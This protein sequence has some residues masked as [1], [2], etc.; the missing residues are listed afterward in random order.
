[1]PGLIAAG[2]RWSIGSD[3]LVIPGA[4]LFFVH[5]TWTAGMAAV[6]SISKEN[7]IGCSPNL[8][9]YILGYIVI[10]CTCLV[11]EGWT[12]YLSLKGTIFY[13]RPRKQIAYLL[14]ARAGILVLEIIWTGLGIFWLSKWY[15]ECPGWLI[16][17]SVLG[18]VI[19]NLLL[20]CIIIVRAWCAY[21]S[22]GRTF[23]MAKQAERQLAMRRSASR[24]ERKTTLETK[25]RI[26]YEEKWDRRF[27]KYCCC[28]GVREREESA[29]TEVAG[30]FSEFFRDLD[31]VS[32]DIYAGLMLLREEQKQRRRAIEYNPANDT[33]KFLSGVPITPDTRFID[34]SNPE[35]ERDFVDLMHYF[36]YAAA[37][38]GWPVYAMLHPTTACCK[39]TS[40]CRCCCSRPKDSFTA[41]DDNCCNCNLA[42]L[43]KISGLPNADFVYATFHSAMEF[44]SKEF[45]LDMEGTHLLGNVSADAN[46]G[47]QFNNSAKVANESGIFLGSSLS[48]QEEMDNRCLHQDGGSTS[49]RDGEVERTTSTTTTCMPCMK[50]SRMRANRGRHLNNNTPPRRFSAQRSRTSSKVNSDQS[51]DRKLKRV[52]ET[53]FFIAL[54]HDRQQVVVAVRGT[55]SMQDWLTDLNA[56]TQNISGGGDGSH[57]YGHKGIV[58]AAHYIK[59]KLLDERLL[60]R[61]FSH[62]V[63][64]GTHQYGLILVGHSLGAGTVAILGMLLRPEFPQ[65][66]CYAYSP[67]GG[68]LSWSAAHYTKEF[69]TSLVIGK[70]LVIR[71]GLSQMETFRAD[72][73]NCMKTCHDAKWEIICGGLLCCCK[74]SQK[75]ITAHDGQLS[76]KPTR[77]NAHYHPTNMECLLTS[78]NPLYP[79][80]RIVH[81][82]RNNPKREGMDKKDCGYYAVWAETESFDEV[83][84]SPVMIGDHLPPNVIRALRKM[85]KKDCGYYAVWAETESFDE[86]LVSPVMIGDHLPPNVIRALRKCLEFGKEH[87]LSKLYPPSSKDRLSRDSSLDRSSSSHSYSSTP[88]HVMHPVSAPDVHQTMSDKNL[89][90]VQVRSPNL[91]D[92]Y[93]YLPRSR[94]MET[95]PPSNTQERHKLTSMSHD[96]MMIAPSPLSCSLSHVSSCSE[97]SEHCSQGSGESEKAAPLARFDTMSELQSGSSHSTVASSSDIDSRPPYPPVDGYC[98]YTD[99]ELA[100]P[101]SQMGPH[102]NRYTPSASPSPS[103]SPS[104]TSANQITTTAEIEPNIA[105]MEGSTQFLL[106]NS[107]W[108]AATRGGVASAIQRFENMRTRA[109]TQDRYT[110]TYDAESIDSS[111]TLEGLPIRPSDLPSDLQ[112]VPADDCTTA[113]SSSNSSPITT[114]TG[115]AFLVNIAGM[116]DYST[117]SSSSGASQ[118]MVDDADDVTPT[119]SV[120]TSPIKPNHPSLPATTTVD[121]E[122]SVRSDFTTPSTPETMLGFAYTR[123]HPLT[124]TEGSETSEIDNEDGATPT[125]TPSFSPIPY[126]PQ[127]YAQ[128]DFES[129]S[130]D[131]RVADANAVFEQIQKLVPESGA[132]RLSESVKNSPKRRVLRSSTPRNSPKRRSRESKEPR[133]PRKQTADIKNKF[134]R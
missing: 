66:H 47:G 68:L 70:D 18:I 119:P 134:I 60:A 129:D 84:V 78:H 109:S 74:I 77:I 30:L 131:E 21:D 17:N 67:P 53:P 126:L 106:P 52:W 56:D 1:M 101:K 82:L 81:I 11:L 124:S 87:G 34:F 22:A 118:R 55:L 64:R 107:P 29:F 104:E 111:T 23:V 57:W 20:V 32:S 54:D 91:R 86:V 50:C 105:S 130:D 38:Y 45:G 113:S 92:P 85:D 69:V 51:L 3:D 83:L 93:Q 61:A 116:H 49:E 120:T 122:R 114:P 65:L 121:D 117:T 133:E 128:R 15:I 72:L 40:R 48:F 96:Q 46:G 13:V 132:L 95:A 71:M 94:S 108:P 25:T 98:Y 90:I 35:E 14:Y 10:L 110:L 100:S 80:G 2:R 89:N 24:V 5:L 112:F 127:S 37:A 42:A 33:I 88:V 28:A 8:Y 58:Q 125:P 4:I 62:D 59:K 19:Y 9:R 75:N 123:Y 97:E 16:K 36:K 7:T 102:G 73:L 41:D 99:V 43:K 63:D 27:R 76:P 103:P 44:L 31:L 39:L 6:I 12:V 79:P 26:L 115:R